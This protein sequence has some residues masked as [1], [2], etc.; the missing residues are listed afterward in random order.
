MQR[1]GTVRRPILT[2]WARA[3]RGSAVL[4]AVIAGALASACREATSPGFALA[5][6]VTSFQGPSHQTDDAGQPALWCGVGLD[7]HTTGSGIAVWRGGEF[8]FYLPLDRQSPVDSAAVP[9]SEMAAAWGDSS[10][11]ADSVEQSGWRVNSSAPFAFGIKFRYQAFDRAPDSTTVDTACTPA[12]S[13]GPPPVITSLAIDPSSDVEPGKALVIDLGA[14]SAVGFWESIVDLSGACDTTVYFDDSLKSTIARKVSIVLPPT[15]TLGAPLV[16]NVGVV[17]ALVQF[18][19]GS[20][21]TSVLVDRTPPTTGLVV[22]TPYQNW[23]QGGTGGGYLFTGDSIGVVISASDNRALS[24]VVWEVLP[25]GYRDSLAVSGPAVSFPLHIPVPPGWLGDSLRVRAY[26]RDSS[27]NVSVPELAPD[28]IVVL[29]TFTAPGAVAALPSGATDLAVDTA[30]DLVYALEPN[31]GTVAIFSPASGA[32]TGTITLPEAVH[33]FDITASG[34]SIVT[35]LPI[36]RALGIVDL[37]Q[38]PPAMT[39]NALAGLDSTTSPWYV[40][41]TTGG[42]AFLLEIGV[43]SG[44]V[45]SYDLGSSTL[46]RRLDAG[47]EGEA[48]GGP[49]ERSY[50]R[51]AVVV[52]GSTSLL[53]RYDAV[54][55]SFGT[56]ATSVEAG[57]RPVLDGAGRH[58]AVDRALYDSA[59]HRL[60]N[61]RDL[62]VIAALSPDGQTAYSAL[63]NFWPNTT[64]TYVA[65]SAVTDGRVADR[66]L[67][68]IVGQIHLSPDG[69]KLVLVGFVPSLNTYGIG[70]V[71]LT[72]LTPASVRVPQRAVVAIHPT[73]TGAGPTVARRPASARPRVG[74]VTSAELLRKV[75]RRRAA[76]WFS[77]VLRGGGGGANSTTH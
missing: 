46:R 25:V 40:R 77:P 66:I 9:A 62:Q 71:D 29:P 26:A 58:V 43:N 49:I 2:A 34:D 28:T 8:Y 61:M 73:V 19:S 35:A 70:T 20:L 55:D 21:T 5:I 60:P 57:V 48:G 17:D 41:M 11:A 54:S 14:Q 69:K 24:Y 27:G 59:L 51:S 76:W 32:V 30:R 23:S 63:N 13:P 45:Y 65:R 72:R 18:A 1:P 47:V 39:T 53:Q 31:S 16:A 37:L 4:V 64:P 68:P 3:C 33:S 36:A 6:A 56:I 12:V 67:T 22:G 74:Q 15:C 75:L 10:I 38:S 50:D 52:N 42:R 44:H 7:A